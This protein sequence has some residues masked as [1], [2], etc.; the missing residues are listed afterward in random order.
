[1]YENHEKE[2]RKIITTTTI[3]KPENTTITKWHQTKYKLTKNQ[4]ENKYAAT[5]I[6]E[7]TQKYIVN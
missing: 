6:K 7:Q 4:L 2:N 5:E 3:N 1:M